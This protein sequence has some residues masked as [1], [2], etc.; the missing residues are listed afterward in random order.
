MFCCIY[1]IIKCSH[2]HAATQIADASPH[3]VSR[4]RRLRR[5][6]LPNCSPTPDLQPQ[7]RASRQIRLPPHR[8]VVH[9]GQRNLP[10]CRQHFAALSAFPGT[11]V[12]P[13]S[14]CADIDCVTVVLCCQSAL[15]EFP[16]SESDLVNASI[17]RRPAGPTSRLRPTANW[18][19]HRTGYP[20][21]PPIT[22]QMPQNR[23]RRYAT[24]YPR[25][26]DKLVNNNVNP[27]GPPQA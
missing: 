21:R 3:S 27:T 20:C 19:S 5:Q 4:R 24:H 11:P 6:M 2:F 18:G 1:W 22:R 23:P 8:A 14:G 10:R 13:L 7:R 12:M 26:Y 9:F 16:P 17:V 15:S 25:R